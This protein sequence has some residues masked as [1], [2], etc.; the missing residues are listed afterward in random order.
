MRQFWYIK[1]TCVVLLL[2]ALT[3]SSVTGYNTEFP[4]H[5][6][7]W[8]GSAAL[9]EVRVSESCET[10]I[11]IVSPY[12]ASFDLYAVRNNGTSGTCP[13][14]LDIIS[15]YDRAA[16]SERGR[17]SLILQEGLWC[18]VVYARLGAGSVYVTAHSKCDA[19][20]QYPTILPYPASNSY[21]SNEQPGY[22]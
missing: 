16:I 2:Y 6:N 11:S 10:Q 14:N 13:S 3:I 12:E 8:E 20:S 9:H 17:A 7:L 22:L 21:N 15:Y 18:V 4:T 5:Y 1:I 19:P